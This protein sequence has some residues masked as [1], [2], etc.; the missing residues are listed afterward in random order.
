MDGTVVAAT[1]NHHPTIATARTIDPTNFATFSEGDNAELNQKH[2]QKDQVDDW[3]FECR[4]RKT[5][6]EAI[7]L[8]TD[9]KIISTSPSSSSSFSSL[10]TSSSSSSSN[11]AGTAYREALRRTPHLV[12]TESDPMR[13]F[14]L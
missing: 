13:F 7:A 6:S 12:E 5:L 8:I 10:S 3:E 9:N 4:A 2:P 1:M 11:G 14:A